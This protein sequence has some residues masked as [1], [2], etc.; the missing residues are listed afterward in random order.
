MWDEEWNHH[1]FTHEALT[2]VQPLLDNI[3]AFDLAMLLPHGIL[4]LEVTTSKNYTR[5]DNVSA[6]P[7]IAEC[8]ISCDTAPHLHPPHTDHFPISFELDISTRTS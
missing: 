7:D 6:S 5:P 1:L 8:L 2:K 3:I 4:T